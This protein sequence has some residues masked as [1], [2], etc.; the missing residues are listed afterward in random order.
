MSKK[1]AYGALS[2]QDQWNARYAHSPKNRPRAYS[3][4]LRFLHAILPRLD[5]NR[6]LHRWRI[7]DRFFP[8]GGQS[9]F[10]E[11]GCAPGRLLMEYHLR[12]GCQPW[13]V[14]YSAEGVRQARQLLESQGLS[15]SQ[16]IEG[17]FFSDETLK[18]LGNSFDVVASH[19][20]IEHFQDPEMVI[21]RQLTLLRGGGILITTIPNLRWF[22]YLR[23]KCLSP[24]ALAMHNLAIM[25]PCAFRAIFEPLDLEHRKR[26]AE[27]VGEER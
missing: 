26:P 3:R 10:L 27:H 15:P 13:G 6:N 8:R 14:D 20:F 25:K 4:F 23:A 1:V 18:R 12:Y 2:R 24:N 17:D 19:G 21:R 22:N 16:V 9:R 7:V 11:V 5:T